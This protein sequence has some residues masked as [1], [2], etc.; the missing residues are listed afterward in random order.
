LQMWLLCL[1]WRRWCERGMK[2]LYTRGKH[3]IASQNASY[4]WT[5]PEVDCCL[6]L[7]KIRNTQMH[8][9]VYK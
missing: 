5:Q 6:E 2:T 8:V 4:R 3:R 1:C 7:K 9:R